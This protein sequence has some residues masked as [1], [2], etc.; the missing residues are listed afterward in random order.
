MSVQFFCLLFYWI[1][2]FIAIEL[3]RFFNFLDINP[4]IRYTI[5]KYFLPFSRLPFHFLDSFLCCAEVIWLDVVSLVYILLLLPLL[6][7]SNPKKERKTVVKTNV[8]EIT[9]M[10][11]SRSVMILGL[12]VQV[13]NP[14]WVCFCVW[15]KIEIQSHSFAR[16]CPVFPTP[17]ME[18]TIPSPS[19]FVAASAA[20][21]SLPEGR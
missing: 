18:E 5:C 8:K 20:A 15:C 3:Y 1:I 17:F 11:S 13:F 14:F 16:G 2:C 19:I 9:P 7:V 4:F 12:Y 10:F 6:L 21:K